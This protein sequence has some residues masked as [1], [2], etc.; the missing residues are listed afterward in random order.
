MQN[1]TYHTTRWTVFIKHDF[2]FPYHLIALHIVCVCVCV[3]FL[4]Y[5]YLKQY[6]ETTSTIKLIFPNIEAQQIYINPVWNKAGNQ[7]IRRHL[8]N[9]GCKLQF[10]VPVLYYKY[11]KFSPPELT[12]LSVSLFLPNPQM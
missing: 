7:R 9:A 4:K 11:L 12:H 3:F 6:V 2:F 10:S 1:F 5:K 8:C